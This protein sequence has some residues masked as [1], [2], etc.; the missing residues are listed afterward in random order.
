MF[1]EIVSISGVRKAK[2]QAEAWSGP[3]EASGGSTVTHASG[4]PSSRARRI[5][6]QTGNPA[7]TPRDRGAPAMPSA[8]VG[9]A[10]SGGTDDISARV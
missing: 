8:S 4:L 6:P 7:A 10:D 9:V 2:W 1:A 3:T 5:S